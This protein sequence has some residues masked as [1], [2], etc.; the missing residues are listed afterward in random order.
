MSVNIVNKDLSLNRLASNSTVNL[1][2][3][4]TSFAKIDVLFEGSKT[5]SGTYS[6]KKS[7]L[8]YDYIEIEFANKTYPLY[9]SIKYYVDK[10]LASSSSNAIRYYSS[11]TYNFV[12]YRNS[13]TSSLYFSKNTFTI[14]RILGVK[15]GVCKAT[16]DNP[17]QA[18]Y[19]STSTT[20]TGGTWIDGKPIY[21]RV[22]EHTL[23]KSISSSTT[24]FTIPLNY[25]FKSIVD[26]KGFIVLKDGLT[27]T[28][29]YIDGSGNSVSVYLYSQDNE[30]TITNKGKSFDAGTVFRLIVDYTV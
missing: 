4:N 19:Y 15:L 28:L 20:L 10:I 21:R 30:F 12:F 26:F 6:L 8:T 5:G 24:N 2:T 17:Q 1:Y 7:Y 3:N 29:P 9:N 16:I 22:T 11:T 14:K 18:D 13:S 25:A 23:T 27:Y